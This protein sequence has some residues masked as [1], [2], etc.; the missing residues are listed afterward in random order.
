LRGQQRLKSALGVTKLDLE[1][2][3]G[4]MHKQQFGTEFVVMMLVATT[5]LIFDRLLVDEHSPERSQRD[6]FI[7]SSALFMLIFIWICELFI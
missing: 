5:I 7:V 6:V 3:L 4:M 2:R 1:V